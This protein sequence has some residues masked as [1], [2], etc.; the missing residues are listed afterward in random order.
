MRSI[1]L[2]FVIFV[3]VNAINYVSVRGRVS[4]VA[5]ESGVT[6]IRKMKDA[7]I[8]IWEYNNVFRDSH[9]SLSRV[10]SDE[11]GLFF[12]EGKHK[13]DQFYVHIEF[14]CSRIQ[15]CDFQD[16]KKNCTYYKKEYYVVTFS[17]GTI[18][19]GN[20]K[21]SIP[22]RFNYQDVKNKKIFPLD[23][24][25]GAEG[26]R[27]ASVRGRVSC[28]AT[29]D[30]VAFIRKMKVA[31][32][33]IWEDDSNDIWRFGDD[34]QSKGHDGISDEKGLFVA[35]AEDTENNPIYYMKIQFPCS[36]AEKCDDTEFK[37]QCKN[38]PRRVYY[39]ARDRLDIPIRYNYVNAKDKERYEI[40]K[41]YPLDFVLG[42]KNGRDVFRNKPEL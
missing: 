1:L 27:D 19:D 18:G 12:V 26:D 36:N 35:E 41:I 32:I 38:H 6:F 2:L 16:F 31:L 40:V 8:T 30:G 42:A 3:S 4:C 29:E 14:P 24:I 34:H 9:V 20:V 17:R 5:T 37:A 10:T 25:L 15:E 33:E 39:M 23:F 22:N 13:E 11:K 28:M 21:Y 7:L